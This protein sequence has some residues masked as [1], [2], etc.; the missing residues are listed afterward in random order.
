MRCAPRRRHE[1]QARAQRSALLLN[2]HES[3]IVLAGG[4]AEANTR[5]MLMVE[6]ER[7][8]T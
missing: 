1:F 5:D 6:V 8:V 3:R 4:F 2:L 7:S